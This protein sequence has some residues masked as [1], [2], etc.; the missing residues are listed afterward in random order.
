MKLKRNLHK[1]IDQLTIS[2]KQW[3]PLHTNSALSTK[4]K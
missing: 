4:R 3:T 1:D 2:Q